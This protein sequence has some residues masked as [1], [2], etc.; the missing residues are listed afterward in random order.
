MRRK[1]IVVL[2]NPLAAIS[3]HHSRGNPED[4]RLFPEDGKKGTF[5][6]GE[7]GQP[8]TTERGRLPSIL[9]ARAPKNPN[10][11]LEPGAGYF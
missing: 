3:G 5:G 6:T 9:V 8:Q 4:H 11:T 10:I 7:I 1:E 2:K